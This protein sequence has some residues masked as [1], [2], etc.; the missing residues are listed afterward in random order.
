MLPE[1]QTPYF[2]NELI[3]SQRK[4]LVDHGDTIVKLNDEIKILKEKIDL[5]EDWIQRSREMED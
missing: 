3:E 4:L 2:Q 1:H 5:L